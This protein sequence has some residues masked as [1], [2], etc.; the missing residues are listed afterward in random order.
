MNSSRE[1]Q[2]AACVSIKLA[3]ETLELHPERCMWWA[4]EKTLLVSDVH[5]GK[6]AHFRKNGIAIPKDVNASSLNR[7]EN[8]IC[9][10][11]PLRLL[12]LGDLF[13]SA[14]NEE[15]N[16]FRE[17]LNR[18]FSAHELEEFRLVEGNHDVLPNAAFQGFKVQRSAR[19]SLG[20]FDFVHDPMDFQLAQAPGRIGIAG[21]LH[22]AIHLAGKAKQ[23]LRLPGWW[24]RSKHQT[25]VM[26]NF[27]TFTGSSVV[28]VKA[29]DQFWIC[30]GQSVMPAG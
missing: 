16:D 25:L 10:Y 20:P 19:W 2:D 12:V 21:H 6:S 15:W 18:I 8:V 4:K 29:G 26:P 5:L 9:K 24:F 1:P 22:P 14:L 13:H 28:N 27:G 17:W 30:T 7:L 3:G 11:Q 23:Q